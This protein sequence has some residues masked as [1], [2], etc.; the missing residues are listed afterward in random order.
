MSED[1]LVISY[2][3]VMIVT[4]AVEWRSRYRRSLRTDIATA[5]YVVI[6]MSTVKPWPERARRIGAVPAIAGYVAYTSAVE[7]EWTP[8]GSAPGVC[9]AKLWLP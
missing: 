9:S 6:G 5:G 7:T 1:R 8:V 3:L 2:S 4:A